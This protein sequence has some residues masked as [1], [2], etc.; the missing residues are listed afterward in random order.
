MRFLYGSRFRRI[1][2][3]LLSA[4]VLHLLSPE[5]NLLQRV[6]QELRDHPT[7]SLIDCWTNPMHTE[8]LF[9]ALMAGAF[10][11]RT[12]EGDIYSEE[13]V[14]SWL[15]ETG[16]RRVDCTPLGSRASMIVAT[17]AS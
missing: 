11:L 12:G 8:P 1:T 15:E 13:E 10:L 16:W 2:T 3:L 6:R 5:H 17:T 14:C 9:A 7:L 4:N